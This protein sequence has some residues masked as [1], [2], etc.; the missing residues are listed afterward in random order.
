MGLRNRERSG[1]S[2]GEVRLPLVEETC[3]CQWKVLGALLFRVVLWPTS[4]PHRGSR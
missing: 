1:N 2:T 3:Q 4:Q